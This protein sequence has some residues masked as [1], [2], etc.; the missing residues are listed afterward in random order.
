LKEFNFTEAIPGEVVLISDLQESMKL[1]ALQ[2][3]AWPANT[4][5]IIDKLTPKNAANASIQLVSSSENL[6]QGNTDTQ[7]KVKVLNSKASSATRFTLD[8]GVSNTS[9]Y[10]AAGAQ[11]NSTLPVPPDG[12]IKLAGD[13]EPFDNTL[14]VAPRGKADLRVLYIGSDNPDLPETD[15]F[16]LRKA[17]LQASNSLIQMTQVTGNAL[18]PAAL[19]KTPTLI[20]AADPL[21]SAQIQQLRGAVERGSVLCLLPRG[22]LMLPLVQAFFP[23]IQQI[24]VKNGDYLLEKLD[25]KDSLLAPFAE[26]RFSDFT[27]IHVWKYH[28]LVGS[29]EGIKVVAR[30]EGGAP[31]IL[32]TNAGSGLVFAITFGWNPGESQL[33]LS[34][35]FIPLVYSLLEQNRELVQPG[36]QYFIGENLPLKKFNQSTIERPDGKTDR[37]ENA[38]AYGKLDVPGIYLI[39]SQGETQRVAVNLHP[40]ESKSETFTED[41]F[42]ALGI[43][44]GAPVAAAVSVAA[45]AND[46]GKLE[47]QQRLWR[48][49]VVGVIGFLLLEVFTAILV[50]RREQRS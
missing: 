17:F 41:D 15:L 36:S 50:G 10:A 12:K 1:S 47:G 39:K 37:A 32:R 7:I 21:S 38:A 46:P 16:F 27:K 4:R 3:Q 19:E 11:Q 25:L 44:I 14:Y 34:S 13:A 48:W 40:A 22:D 9:V 18:T 49:A 2:Q 31:G 23:G 6:F 45:A 35:K 26:P 29:H 33:G 42:S 30:L 43:K 20:V 8:S 28:D 24:E 5:L